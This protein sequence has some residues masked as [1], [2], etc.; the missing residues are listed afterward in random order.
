MSIICVVL[1]FLAEDNEDAA[2]AG[3]LPV[4]L[5]NFN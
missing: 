5:K 1:M 3:R 4:N 2:V